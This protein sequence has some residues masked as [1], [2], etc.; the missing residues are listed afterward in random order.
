[1]L[2]VCALVPAVFMLGCSSTKKIDVSKLGPPPSTLEL[3][4]KHNQRIKPLGTLWA[5]ISLRAKGEY[6]DGKSYEEQGEGHLQIDKP[7]NI[8]LTI[9]KLGETYF[10]FGANSEEYW[11][12]DLSNSDHKLAMI[13]KLD[14]ATP[15]KIEALGLPVYPGELIALTGLMPIDMSRAGGSRWADDGKSVGVSVP[16]RWGSF[17]LWFNPK[18]S[19]VVRSQVFNHDGELI[20]TASLSRYKD[21]SIPDYGTIL[22]PGKIEVTNPNDDGW[23]RIELSGPRSK[24]IKPR[25]YQPQKLKRAYR[26][27]ETIDLDAAFDTPE[28]V[29][30]SAQGTDGEP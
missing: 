6:P 14:L 30:D 29:V 28:P 4:E 10:A 11:S 22:V 16:S 13:G 3:A 1:M 2:V 21:A 19:L 5:R 26:V 27:D 12:F 9:G 23:V 20:A 17:T 15:E 7:N 18:T 8:S 24:P 25:V